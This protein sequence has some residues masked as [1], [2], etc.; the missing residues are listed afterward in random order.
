MV[1]SDRVMLELDELTNSWHQRDYIVELSQCP[2]PIDSV[3]YKSE[4][5]L[6]FD[7]TENEKIPMVWGCWVEFLL[8]YKRQ[9]LARIGRLLRMYRR[10]PNDNKNQTNFD[11][12]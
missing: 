10:L 6:E 1:Y 5:L 2:Y 4:L 9:P 7:C 8:V 3:R 12:F 11:W